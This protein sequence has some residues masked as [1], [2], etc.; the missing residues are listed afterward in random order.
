M[1][2]AAETRGS[3]PTRAQVRT[4]LAG[5]AF[6]VLWCV[7]AAALLERV[8]DAWVIFTFAALVLGPLLCAFAVVLGCSLLFRARRAP[9]RTRHTLT[10]NATFSFLVAFLALGA[11]LPVPARVLWQYLLD[12][13]TLAW[14][15]EV[16]GRIQ[17]YE[18]VHGMYPASLSDLGDLGAP[19]WALELDYNRNSSGFSLMVG[20]PYHGSGEDR[21]SGFNSRGCRW[22]VRGDDGSPKTSVPSVPYWEQLRYLQGR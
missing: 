8:G 6:A 14:S 15:D 7:G 1:A 4:L 2:R 22:I 12:A 19:W 16:V 13:P 5:F 18:A 3:F 20:P 10:W 9:L 17:T 21:R 11:A